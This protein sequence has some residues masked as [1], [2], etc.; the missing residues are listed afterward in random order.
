MMLKQTSLQALGAML[1]IPIVLAGTW[2]NFT[3]TPIDYATFKASAVEG[4]EPFIGPKG[5]YT[6]VDEWNLAYVDAAPGGTFSIDYPTEYADLIT[7]LAP[8]NH[9][10]L[11]FLN[12]V[13]AL[14]RRAICGEVCSVGHSGGIC[15]TCGCK[16]FEQICTSQWSCYYVYRCT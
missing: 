7:A 4:H 1:F 3:T 16:F 10:G 11:D 15:Q 9:D 5:L 6:K 12:N 13:E 14:E 2:G 8:I